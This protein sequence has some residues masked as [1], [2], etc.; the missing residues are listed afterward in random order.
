ML[1]DAPYGTDDQPEDM[2]AAPE[3]GKVT[4]KV[5]VAY[6]QVIAL[7]LAAL[8]EAAAGVRVLCVDATSSVKNGAL[9]R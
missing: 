8:D 1:Y 5:C 2:L 7:S 4:N 6:W 9:P 3:K